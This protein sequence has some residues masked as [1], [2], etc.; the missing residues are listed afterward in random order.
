MQARGL[1]F[2]LHPKMGSCFK[3]ISH[4]WSTATLHNK[5]SFLWTGYCCHQAETNLDKSLCMHGISIK[6]MKKCT[7]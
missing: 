1:C 6:A 2:F 3:V 7:S 4:A 5:A